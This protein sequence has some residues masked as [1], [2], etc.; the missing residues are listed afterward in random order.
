MAFDTAD[1]VRLGEAAI[2]VVGM[3]YAAV[4]DVR[5]REA[6]DA[7]WLVL[8]SIAT[9]AGLALAFLEGPLAIFLWVAV[10]A[11]VLEHLL[12]WDEALERR[13][14]LPIWIVEVVAYAAV[15]LVIFA[16]G[17][18]QDWGAQ[19]GFVP[20]AGVFVTVLFARGLFE[21]RVLYGGADAKALMALGLLLP[22]WTMTLVPLPTMAGIV[23]GIVPFA[24]TALLNA[25]LLAVAV[26]VYLGLRNAFRREFEFPRALA[27]YRI[28]VEELPHRF[29]WLRD[30]TLGVSPD[31]EDVETSDEDQALRT[32]QMI[33]LKSR[34]MERVWVTPQLPFLLGIALGAIT[35]LVA[36]NLLFDLLV[37]L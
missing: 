35:A 29:V 12:P 15:G 10:S 9:F 20:A 19:P 37:L 25:A 27:S 32:R 13:S 28:P 23:T 34:G 16:I 14:E 4:T 21:A 1:I 7:L 5:T 22:F 11:L 33:E 3:S 26:P 2:V 31:E 17:Y 36:G 8:A 24:V 18:S 6:P 30:A